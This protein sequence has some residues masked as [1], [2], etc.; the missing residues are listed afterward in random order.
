MPHVM[1]FLRQTGCLAC[2]NPPLKSLANTEL[3]T[4]KT[5]AWSA[6]H[7]KAHIETD[8]AHRCV[9]TYTRAHG[10]AEC[11]QA[12]RKGRAKHVAEIGEQRGSKLSKKWETQLGATFEEAHPPDRVP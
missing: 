3:N 11:I 2:V 5:F 1:S 7:N 10:I 6:V 8:G 4:A 12:I 9:I